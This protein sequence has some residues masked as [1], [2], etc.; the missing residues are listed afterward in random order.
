MK[1]RLCGAEAG[2]LR[3]K[4]RECSEEADVL[5]RYAEDA[6]IHLDR[7][8]TFAAAL[9]RSRLNPPTRSDIVHQGYSASIEAVL[10]GS[11]INAAEEAA[12][13]SYREPFGVAESFRAQ[14]INEGR[15][16]GAVLEGNA[17]GIELNVA[18]VQVPF[19]LQR[20]ENLVFVTNARYMK[21]V[22]EREFRGQS[23]GMSVRVAK[24]IYLRPGAFRGRPVSKS[25]FKKVDSGMLGVT[26]KHLYFA[27]SRERFRVRYDKIV[28]FEPY[29]D[30]LGFMRDSARARPEGFSK[31]NGWFIYNLVSNLARQ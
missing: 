25:S 2:F 17:V 11:A 13:A 26:A 12:L 8:D 21:T 1:C 19:N 16:L 20:G 18:D 5:R 27:G 31:I 30:G 28:A 23:M 29:E 3:L 4:H 24:G 6:A 10:E 9:E 7:L 22:V 14:E 15:I